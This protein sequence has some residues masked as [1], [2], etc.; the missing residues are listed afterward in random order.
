MKDG[1]EAQARTGRY[2]DAGDYV[3]HLIRRDEGRAAKIAHLLESGIS[4]E[5]M[6]D[7]ASAAR[8]RRSG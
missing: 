2:R 7:M 5:S 4:P 8:D 6:E 1:V 3:G